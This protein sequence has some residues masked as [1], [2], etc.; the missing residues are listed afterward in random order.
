[1]F[2]DYIYNQ[3]AALDVQDEYDVYCG[4]P[5]LSKEPPNLIQY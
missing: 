2:N 1:M 3:L 5:P 4:A